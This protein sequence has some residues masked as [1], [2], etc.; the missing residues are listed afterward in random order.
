MLDKLSIYINQ[1]HTGSEYFINDISSFRELCINHLELN[2][3]DYLLNI[4]E[5]YRIIVTITNNES[6]ILT[7]G[8]DVFKDIL[9][10]QLLKNKFDCY[11]INNEFVN[12]S[13][14]L[15]KRI[16]CENYLNYENKDIRKIQFIYNY[17]VVLLTQMDYIFDD[18]ELSE[19]LKKCYVANIM[20]IIVTSRSVYEVNLSNLFYELIFNVIYSMKT[21]LR[22]NSDS[23]ITFRRRYGFFLS[24]FNK[25]YRLKKQSTHNTKS[26]KIR[27]MLFEKCSNNL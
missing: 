15:I 25:Y 10:S 9:L 14:S 4:K 27:F 17:D 3:E 26:G 5:L 18:D 11:D 1:S 21:F 2:A 20:Y 22:K 8:I 13:K 6:K 23:Y 12:S 24:I 7:V 19:I 16:D